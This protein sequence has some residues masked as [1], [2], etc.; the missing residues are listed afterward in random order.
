MTGLGVCVAAERPVSPRSSFGS[1]CVT[2]EPNLMDMR[3]GW[4]RPACHSSALSSLLVS[5]QLHCVSAACSFPPSPLPHQPA[6]AWS[7]SACSLPG[8]PVRTTVWS[9]GP[10]S[11]FW[12]ETCNNRVRVKAGSDGLVLRLWHGIHLDRCQLTA[13]KSAA[14]SRISTL[15]V[16]WLP[17]PSRVW[18]EEL[19]FI[20]IIRLPNQRN[21][22]VAQKLD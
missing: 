6:Q 9:F 18:D 19:A 12:S 1:D 21:V 10:R 16:F 13:G 7:S 4:A 8:R 11:A 14:A 3:P 5:S 17:A 22:T 15:V 2:D 20:N